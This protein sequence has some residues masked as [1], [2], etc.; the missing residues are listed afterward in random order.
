MCVLVRFVCVM[1]L[2]FQLCFFKQKTAYDVRISDW[3][4]DVCSSD[5]DGRSLQVSSRPVCDESRESFQETEGEPEE[6]GRK[7]DGRR[8]GKRKN[9]GDSYMGDRKSVV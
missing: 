4:S 2:L 5:L 9:Q 3:S 6:T 7:R 1:F 8:K